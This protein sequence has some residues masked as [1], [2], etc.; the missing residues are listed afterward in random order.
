ME[1]NMDTGTIIR[2]ILVIATCLNTALMATDLS[3]FDNTTLDTIYKVASVILNFIIVACATYYNNDFTE[4]GAIG[5]QF[6]RALKEDP[7][8]ALL[9]D[10]EDELDE[11]EQEEEDVV[12]EE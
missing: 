12:E 2:T 3:G 11:L 6:T 8:E 9:V 10:E 5:T 1:D 4:E 7:D